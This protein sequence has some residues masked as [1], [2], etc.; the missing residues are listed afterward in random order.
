MALLW[1]TLRL[2]IDGFLEDK[3]LRLSAALSYYSIFSL[4]P[5]ALIAV[6]I[7]G[8]FLGE[9]AAQG[10]LD[11]Q[12]QSMMGD[13]AAA[14]V[15]EMIAHTAKPA[16]NITASLIGFGLLIVGAGGVFS[17]LQDA[18]NTVWGITSAK[19]G[20]LKALIRDRFLAFAMVFGIGILLLA[21]LLLTTLVQAASGTIGEYIPIPPL[22]YHLTGGL[23]SF[24]VIAALFAAIFK[25]LPDALIAWRDVIGGAL[26]TA[27]L[28]MVGKF[29][30]GWYL[31]R[32]ATASGYG[33]A[34][35][36]VLILL[37]VYYSSIILLFGA[38]LTQV[39]SQ[40]K[41]R[42]IQPKP[43]AA[44]IRRASNGEAP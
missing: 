3:I 34:G 10:V 41:G 15:Q 29:G 38:K 13:E 8:F 28:F 9:K 43:G 6:S 40:L 25:I 37:W 16:K 24:L 19:G 44:L 4:A 11:E 12:L 21:S 2:S 33:S 18:L 26:V 35:S 27:A 20:G 23:A 30:M 42:G 5:L 39:N 1:K 32:E 36:L 7:T 31:G 22:I 17:Q 14:T